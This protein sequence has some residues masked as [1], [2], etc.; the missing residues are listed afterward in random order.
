MSPPNPQ[1]RVGKFQS[2][3]HV[4]ARALALFQSW[5]IGKVTR[6]LLHPTRLPPAAPAAHHADVPTGCIP[7]ELTGSPPPISWGPPLRASSKESGG[8]EDVV[9]EEVE[10]AGCVR[11]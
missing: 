2:L 11:E 7:L 6:R 5:V 3:L 4:R 1:M 8:P 10:V 9:G